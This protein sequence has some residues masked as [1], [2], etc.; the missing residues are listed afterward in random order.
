[1]KKKTKLLSL[2]STT[3]AGL[4]LSL[5]VVSGVSYKE[6]SQVDALYN[7]S[8]TYSVSDTA[9]ELATYYSSINNQSG[10]TLLSALRSINSSKYHKNFSYSNFG[11]SSST[12]P[13]VYT[14]YPIGT[15]TKDSN[16][17]IRGSSI[18]SFY[19]KT[20]A[21]SFNKEHVWPNSKGG[22]KV[23]NDIL[24]PRPTISS[25]F[26][27]SL[28]FGSLTNTNKHKEY[29]NSNINLKNN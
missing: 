24:M 7:P 12:S 6:T 21:D 14:D 4:A 27:L 2:I 19:T 22:N 5:G 25:D 26:S 9:S 18:A 1:M 23:E 13:Y 20:T 16:G 3:L 15:T 8:T 17:Q 10:D 29:S 11:T 28:E